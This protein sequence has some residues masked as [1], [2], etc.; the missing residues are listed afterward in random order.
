MGTVHGRLDVRDTDRAVAR[1][2]ARFAR[3]EYSLRA[4]VDAG[5]ADHLESQLALQVRI[6][7]SGDPV[8]AHAAR[9]V[10]Q[11]LLVRLLLRLT[12]ASRRRQDRLARL[13]GALEVR[14]SSL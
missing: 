13:A 7:E 6:R 14:R 3:Y 11:V 5:R 2:R 8:G 9:E 1:A 4:E 12:V 10:Q